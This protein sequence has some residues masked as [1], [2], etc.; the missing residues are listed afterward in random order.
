LVNVFFIILIV[1]LGLIGYSYFNKPQD[2]P[3]SSVIPSPS[4]TTDIEVV[5]KNLA[6]P[7]ALAFL[8][9]E[10]MLM[11][12]RAGRLN[13]IT[14]GGVHLLH[15]LEVKQIGEGGLHGIAVDPD[16]KTNHY[17]YLYYTYEQSG[18]LTLNRVVRF[19]LEQDRVSDQTVIID[20]IPGAMSHDGGRLKFGPDKFLYITTGDAQQPSLSQDPNSLA[21]KILRFKDPS[22]S[23]GQVE[24]YSLGHR[25]PQGIT[26]DDQGRL[27]ETEHGS[28]ATDEINL[29]EQNKNYGWPIIRGDQKQAGL[30]SPILQS[31][32]QTWAPAGAAF[33]QGSVYFGGLKGQTLYQL[34]LDTLKL[35]EHFKG[36]FGRIRDVVL[37]PD[38]MLYITTSNKD[39]RGSPTP[40]DDKIIRL[41]PK[42][43]SD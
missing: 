11:T 5:A 14:N 29:I 15:T 26:W 35:T 3:K 16:F 42:L 8:P 12:E 20:K 17:I 43:L 33:Y 1:S 38:Q 7:W 19:K 30:E 6:V 40:D 21:G 37:G 2:K 9:D 24:V 10:T 34:K 28:Q 25:N 4:P 39:G 23:S 36:Q 13:K 31:G 27:W 22:A 18:N 32:S 41:N